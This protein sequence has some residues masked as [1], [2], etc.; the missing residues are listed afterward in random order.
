[1]ANSQDVVAQLISRA[2]AG[3]AAARAELLDHLSSDLR[4]TAG[5]RQQSL[6]EGC[7]AEQ[8]LAATLDEAERR[9]PLFT[10]NSK[11]EACSWLSEIFVHVSD[12]AAGQTGDPNE[13]ISP[14]SAA[15]KTLANAVADSS[16][17]SPIDSAADPNATL[18]PNTATAKTLTE[19]VDN[20]ADPN[21]TIAFESPEAKK[22]AASTATAAAESPPRTAAGETLAG[23]GP[24]P[25]ATVRP[26]ANATIAGAAPRPAA[27]PVKTFGE[28]EII[29]TIAK[30]GMGVVYKARQRKL[31]R[32]VALKMILAGQFADQ[33]DVDRFYAEA[34]AAGNLDHK[35]IVGIHEV[36]ECEGQHFFSM[37]YVE[38]QG[39]D[40]LVRERPLAPRVAARY[41]RKV[42]A[43]MQHAHDQGILHRDLKPANV[44]VDQRDEPLITDFGLAKRADDQSQMTMAGTVM[45][46]A[47]YMPPEQA[48]GDLDQISAQ[49]DVYSLGATLYELL[50]GKPPFGAANVWETIKQVKESEAVAPRTLNPSVPADLETICLKCLQKEPARRYLTAQE[51]VEELQR[52]LAG[53]PILARPVGPV[54]RLWRWCRR[55]PR[56]AGSI[57]AT[58]LILLAAVVVSNVFRSRA[59]IAR[60]QAEAARQQAEASLD[61]A[62]DAFKFLIEVSGN[63][64][65]NVA[66]AQKIRSELLI[67][68][69]DSYLN[70]QKQVLKDESNPE[71][72]L[73]LAETYYFL[74]DILQDLE[75]SDVPGN[76]LEEALSTLAKLQADN[77][78]YAD[79]PAYLAALGKTLNLLGEVLVSAGRLADASTKF[80]EA[81]ATREKLLNDAPPNHRDLKL[82]HGY[83][84]NSQMNSGLVSRALSRSADDTLREELLAK[85][86]T[87]LTLSQELRG[88]LL[89]ETP[90]VAKLHLDAAIGALALAELSYE[91]AATTDEDLTT[92]EQEFSAHLLEAMNEVTVLQDKDA[93]TLQ[94]YQKLDRFQI[95]HLHAKCWILA[96]N[97]RFLIEE[98]LPAQQSFQAAAEILAQLV[99]DNPDMRTFRS[100]LAGTTMNVGDTHQFLEEYDEAIACF[101]SAA[102]MF[103]QLGDSAGRDAAL[104][105]AGETAQDK[106]EASSAL[107]TGESP[108]ES[109]GSGLA[110]DAGEVP[111]PAPPAEDSAE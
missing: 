41:M 57:A 34:Q 33:T 20:T 17:P 96:G 24:D 109:G 45:G 71:I 79:K 72:Q 87:R 73:E 55:N 95:K 103:Q 23:V 29:E 6:P 60:N 61:N 68:A 100:D 54:E 111:G 107:P 90:E 51:L 53:E 91:R 31:N 52:Y 74:G 25:A 80:D 40:A 5:L 36:G 106:R 92:I 56:I 86:K 3:E 35:N 98:D 105:R 12:S 89:K 15:A 21:A 9:F 44:L 110:P 108:Q 84:Y 63:D 13:T 93:R 14:A 66:G 30:G 59:V 38:G 22:L 26:D 39:L 104:E 70:V 2:R 48:S 16:T 49:S 81:I 88:V 58:F 7:S 97:M 47:S 32:V 85:A 8:L 19:A 83:L 99:A 62:R 65:K 1:M 69:K 18:S 82:W 64:L 10:G 78:D 50:T 11:A 94:D 42:A 67:K 76:L 28:Y 101:E 27:P 75:N 77:P 43:A 37:Q 46:T 4:D 102:E